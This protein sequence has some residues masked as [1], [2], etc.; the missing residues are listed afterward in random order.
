MINDLCVFVDLFVK[1]C[2]WLNVSQM[3]TDDLCVFV[4]YL[5]KFVDD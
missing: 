5:W 1:I 3:G 2:G 4:F